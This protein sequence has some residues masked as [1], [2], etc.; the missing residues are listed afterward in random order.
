M[1]TE[2]RYTRITLRIP[3]DLH[4]DLAEHAERTSKSMNA[5]IIARLEESFSLQALTPH[6]ATMQTL[7]A[8]YHESLDSI[9]KLENSAHLSKMDEI[10]LA[11]EKE[12]VKHL[13]HTIAKASSAL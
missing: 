10:E 5:E 4:K 9:K 3:R 1:D 7:I 6:E 12:V 8:L 13:R 11:H 2:D